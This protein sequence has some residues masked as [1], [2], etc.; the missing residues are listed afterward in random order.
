MQNLEI[1]GEGATTKI[2]RDGDRAIKLYVDAPPHEAENEA[3]RQ[4]FAVEAGLPVPAVFA[5]RK[6]DESVTALDMEYIAGKPIIHE[7]MSIEEQRT[8]IGVM[9]K[10]QCA[11]HAVHATDHT[12]LA[13]RLAWKITHNDF[14]AQP[15]KDSLLS[16]LH[17][18]EGGSHHLC[19]G[20]FHPQN[21]LY[22]GSKYWIIDWVDSTAGNPLADA[23]RT[24][25]IFKQYMPCSAETYLSLF[26]KEAGVKQEDIL[27]WMPII[28]A[29]RL[30]ENMS[31]EMR[32]QLVKIVEE[33]T[34]SALV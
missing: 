6:L 1:V 34:P 24:Y 14:L 17:S 19:H 11:V 25:L 5:V 16:L 27:V 28:A 31:G 32:A 20:D 26:C 2:Y 29:A 22:D 10:L 21:I 3:G 30:R 13:D 23:C 4:T 18:L 12:R 8:A 33:C 15:A 7:A 9:V